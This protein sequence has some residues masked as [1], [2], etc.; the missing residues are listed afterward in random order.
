[1]VADIA[2]VPPPRLRG[3]RPRSPAGFPRWSLRRGETG[4]AGCH[5]MRAL[6][7][8]V[9]CR[10]GVPSTAQRCR[11]YCRDPEPCEQ[12][13]DRHVRR[14][15]CY[16]AMVHRRPVA[17]VLLAF[18][19]LVAQ[20][21]AAVHPLSHLSEPLSGPG[22]PDKHLPHSHVCEQCVAL[23]PLGGALPSVPQVIEPPR[24]VTVPVPPIAPRIIICRIRRPYFSRA[25]PPLA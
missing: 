6:G 21:R 24:T 22:Q 16:F 20:G 13:L 1:M 17:I 11:R 9:T 23:A 19:V 25:P 14:A 18:L 15:A 4:G 7:A 8:G 12:A 10:D 3:Q 2:T 5:G